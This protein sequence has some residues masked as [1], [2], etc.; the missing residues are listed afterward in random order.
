[1]SE[2]SGA[3]IG[4]WPQHLL[5]NPCGNCGQDPCECGRR[6]ESPEMAAVAGKWGTLSLRLNAAAKDGARTYLVLRA[7]RIWGCWATSSAGASG[8]RPGVLPTPCRRSSSG[9]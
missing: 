7:R 8:A 5:W 9:G 6:S 3:T 2:E 4:G 1:M